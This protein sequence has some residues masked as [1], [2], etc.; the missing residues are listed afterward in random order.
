MLRYGEES[1]NHPTSQN[2]DFDNLVPSNR[3]TTTTLTDEQLER[4][5]RNKEKTYPI[6]DLT[7]LLIH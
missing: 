7:H 5:R 3:Q 4:M 6:A 1:S 2:D